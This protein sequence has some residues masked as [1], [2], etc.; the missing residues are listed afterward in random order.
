[1]VAVTCN[2]CHVTSEWQT[3]MRR[4]VVVKGEKKRRK[5]KQKVEKERRRR[6]LVLVR[7]LVCAGGC[8][9]QGDG[10]VKLY[11]VSGEGRVVRRRAVAVEVKNRFIF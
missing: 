6:K 3:T 8:E 4:A 11:H 1:M 9:I 10:D 7:V 2:N 5:K